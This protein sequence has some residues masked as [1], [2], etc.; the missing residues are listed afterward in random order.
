MEV[1]KKQGNSTK[2]VTFARGK[3]TYVVDGD[4]VEVDLDEWPLGL[5]GQPLGWG[6]HELEDRVAE[7]ALRKAGRL[8]IGVGQVGQSGLD[9]VDERDAEEEEGVVKSGFGDEEVGETEDGMAARVSTAGGGVGEDVWGDMIT[10]D[11]EE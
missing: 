6:T 1:M 9:G 7:K 10:I 3:W 4:D 11:D 2:E 5:D 8:D